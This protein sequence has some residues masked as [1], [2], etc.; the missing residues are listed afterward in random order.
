MN[1]GSIADAAVG[2]LF[3]A[4]LIAAWGAASS[5]WLIVPRASRHSHDTLV[6]TA[7]SLGMTAGTLLILAMGFVFWR[8][9]ADFRDPFVPWREDAAL[10]LTTSWGRTWMWGMAGSVLLSGLFLVTPVARETV[11]DR[12]AAWAGATA[13]AAAMCAFPAFT[14]HA[15]GSESLR[16]LLI[17]ADIVHV[18]AAGSWIGGLLFVLCAEWANRRCT[19]QGGDIIT[20]VVPLFSPVALVSAGVLIATGTLAAFFHV[21][22]P[23]ALIESTYGRLLLAK[24]ALVLAVLVL[25]A[26][27]WRR[28][29]PRLRDEGGPEALRLSATRELIVAHVVILVTA[30]L[31]RTSP[32]GG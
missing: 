6:A 18:L 7:R 5:R 11:P 3:F 10:L 2:W 23:R 32:M 9:L 30:L 19:G 20:E 21:E 8:Q 14:G 31:V 22:S 12:R 27:N 28:L 17:P 1:A 25:G 4:T 16:W 29:T 26:I 24:V 15:A 13:V